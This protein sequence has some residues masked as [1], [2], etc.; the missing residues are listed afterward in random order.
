[1]AS[2][3]QD[4][5]EKTEEATPQRREEFRK[6]GQVAMTRELGSAL[7]LF[8]MALILWLLGKYMAEHMVVI[9][10]EG[11]STFVATSGK[12][13]DF[14]P[15]IKFAGLHSFLIVG[16]ILLLTGILAFAASALQIGVMT[17]AEAVEFDLN[18]INPVSGFMKIFSLRSVVEGLK[19]LV[20]IT[21]VGSIT[22][23]TIR[24][25]MKM[26][27]HLVE[28]SIEQMIQYIANITTHLFFAIGIA[29]LTI[30]LVD[31]GYNWWDLEKKMMMT[32]QEIKEEVKNR[33]GNPQIKAR[34]R[35]I[36]R[37]FATKRMMEA[38]PKADVIITNPTHL[39]IALKYDA[40]LPAPQIIA[41]GAD[42]VAEKI[43]EIAKQHGIPIVENKPLARTIY[44]TL[45]IG[46]VIP[47]ELFHAVAEVLAYVYKLKKKVVN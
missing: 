15:A 24:N 29:M 19:S 22:Y 44:K 37:D 43:R 13:G 17:N 1:M 2:E 42:L 47:R 11:L 45:K 35:K 40:G 33:E 31:Y 12:S 4:A 16:P 3:E 20:K 28:F 27:P 26:I 9:V 7:L 14:L 8:G 10:R 36:Q 18:K 38:V 23:F 32:K 21:I 6:Q 46:Q 41:K 39:A 30:A 25:E 34:I 5:G